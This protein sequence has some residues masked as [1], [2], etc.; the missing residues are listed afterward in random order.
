VFFAAFEE[1]TLPAIPMVIGGS[2]L[3][4]GIALGVYGIASTPVAHN[5]SLTLGPG[6]VDLS[7]R[8]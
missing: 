2:L 6:S 8:F 3:T 7:V 5:A 1:N 4:A